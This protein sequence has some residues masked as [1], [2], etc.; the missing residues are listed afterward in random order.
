MKVLKAK[1]GYSFEKAL[2]KNYSEMSTQELQVKYEL[3]SNE[4]QNSYCEDYREK[5]T[6]PLRM[7]KRE[8]SKRGVFI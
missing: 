6:I 5:L 3:T 4:R 2:E 1:K 8:L 7:M